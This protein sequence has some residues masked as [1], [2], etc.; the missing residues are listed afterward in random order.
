MATSIGPTQSSRDSDAGAGWHSQSG[1]GTWQ[2]DVPPGTKSLSWLRPSTLWQS[3]NDVIASHIADP[4]DAARKRWVELAS[5]RAQMASASPDFVVSHGT[6]DAVSLLVVGDPGEG[7]NSQYA[8]AA[9]LPAIAASAD[10]AF[11]C[12]DVIYPTGDRG[13]YGRKFHHPYRHLSLPIYAVPGNHDWYDGLH[14]FMHYFCQLNDDGYRPRFGRGPLAALAARLWRKTPSP[15]IRKSRDAEGVLFPDRPAPSPVQPAPYFAIDA[16][17][18]RFVGIDTGITGHLDDDQ[19]RWLKHVSLS[20]PDRP[21]VL[22]TGKPIYVDNKYHPGTVAGTKETIDEIVKDPRANYV[23]A[24][25]GDIHNYQR[26]PVE[27]EPGRTIQYLV[28]GGGG[29]YMHAT[30]RIPP[31]D[32]NGVREEA[33]RCYPLRRDSL[34]RFSQVIDKKLFGGRGL[35]AV[36]PHVAGRFYQGRKI[37]TSNADRPVAQR[38]SLGDRLRAMLVHRLPAG[39]LFHRFGS[40]AF[41][42]DDPPFFKQFLRIDAQGSKIT[43]TC[44][45]VTGSADTEFAPSVEDRFTIEL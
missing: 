20:T 13:D 4:T 3:R 29:A 26:Y 24:I 17:P 33:F 15:Q 2:K 18:L 21:K 42:F 28:S 27:V 34:A 44:Y 10:F 38:L 36:E 7:D 43:V 14:G 19:Y 16:G 9:A 40:E 5:E 37:T 31:V 35:L 45:G 25:G 1:P 12:S 23:L 32:V 41:D 6:A 39:R 11:I 22:L 30:H 8:V